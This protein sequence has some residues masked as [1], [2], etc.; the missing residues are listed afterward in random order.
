[1]FEGW[2]FPVVASYLDHYVK[3]FQ[4]EQVRMRARIG[5]TP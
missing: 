4:K 3:D 5:T 1:M 2:L